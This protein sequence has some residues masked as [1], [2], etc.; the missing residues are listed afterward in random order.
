MLMRIGGGREEERK[1]SQ[2]VN[3]DTVNQDPANRKL[4]S[5]KCLA[6]ANDSVQ[7]PTTRKTRKENLQS[8][9]LERHL[10]P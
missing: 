7:G 4:E 3:A 6:H 5:L 9:P 2:R 8:V 1:G 10:K